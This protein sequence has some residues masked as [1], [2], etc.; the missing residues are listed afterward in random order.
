MEFHEGAT[1][2]NLFMKIFK[3]YKLKNI[4]LDENNEINSYI[5]VL[6]NGRNIKYIDGI[7]TNLSEGDVI[8]F[9]PPVAG[10]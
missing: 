5:N 1:I 7:N 10:G 9:F 3:K 8:A 6:K 2:D 4:L